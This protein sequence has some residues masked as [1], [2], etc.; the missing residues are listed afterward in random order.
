MVSDKP[1][2]H[3]LW[4]MAA[5][6]PYYFEPN[7]LR[8]PEN[9]SIED[10]EVDNRLKKIIL[11]T[12]QSQLQVFLLRINLELDGMTSHKHGMVAKHRVI[13]AASKFDVWASFATN[14]LG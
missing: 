6:E 10:S 4:D 12:L 14:F 9:D 3:P 5:L 1:L 8:A 11:L 13:M 7:M 2:N